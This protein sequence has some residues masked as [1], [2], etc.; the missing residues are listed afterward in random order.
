MK[1]GIYSEDNGKRWL[2][3]YKGKRYES[4]KLEKR[5]W[6]SFIAR[7]NRDSPQKALKL[8]EHYE[9]NIKPKPTNPYGY[10]F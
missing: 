1:D 5:C 6:L 9:K 4:Y 3:I 8:Q 10:R 2:Y 7:I